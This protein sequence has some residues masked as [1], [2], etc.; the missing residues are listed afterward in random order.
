MFMFMKTIIACGN[1]NDVIKN[2]HFLTFSLYIGP[3][4][5]AY[6]QI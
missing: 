4:K 6:L 2:S 3:Y 1:N 5:E